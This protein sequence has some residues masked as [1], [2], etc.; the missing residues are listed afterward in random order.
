VK[1][2]AIKSAAHN[3]GHS[4]VSLMNWSDGD[5]TMSHLTRE[6][7][8]RGLSRLEVNLLTGRAEPEEL[9][10]PPVRA[11]IRDHVDWFPRL[12]RSQAIDPAVVRRAMFVLTFE[13]GRRSVSSEY[14][15]GWTIPFE[16]VITIEDDHG[17]AH[18]GR[19]RDIW[20]VD[21]SFAPP[22]R[23]RRLAWWRDAMRQWWTVHVVRTGRPKALPAHSDRASAD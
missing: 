21:E 18:V 19:V 3:Y 16:C 6:V 13:L 5:Y 22:R 7:V 23:L 14:G 15:P 4:F 2:K 17:R 8:E 10:V 12:L 20:R 9:L 11:S 1:Y